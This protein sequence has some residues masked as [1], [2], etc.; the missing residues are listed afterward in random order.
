MIALIAGLDE[1]PVARRNILADR[2]RLAIS[3]LGVGLAVGLI[4]LLE[5]LFGGLQSQMTAYPDHVGATLFAQQ[6]GAKTLGE[7]V[8]PLSAVE[9][10]RDITGV[11]AADQVVVR[12]VILDLHGTKEAVDLVGFR[13][14]G[15]GGPWSIAAGRTVR[16]DGEV[17]IDETLADDHAIG[18]GGR[19]EISDRGF[20]VVGLSS[21][22]RTFMTGGYVFL[23]LSSA[24]Q[25]LAET[26]TATFIL[27]RTATPDHVS[28]AIPE[29]TG[30][31]AVRPEV[32]AQ[33]DRELYVGAL[34][35][36]LNL[37]ILIAF[38]AGTLIVAFT[39]HAAIVERIHEYGT[40]KAIGARSGRLFRIVAGQALV[41]AALGTA[42]GFFLYV[43]A[44]R[45]IVAIAPQFRSDLAYSVGGVKA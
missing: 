16:R 36:P 15:M 23:S 19:L 27:V 37:M 2:R 5:G 25:L 13:P 40:V 17:V 9:Q 30:L 45:L 35:Q 24:Q 44:S 1:V 11:E 34:G 42:A 32:V 28:D 31:Q 6:P 21:G 43:A 3:A 12:W 38:V 4:L 14:G 29:G 18:L 22:T 7:G 10:V 41:V 8:V 26:G 39:V 33:N 20:R